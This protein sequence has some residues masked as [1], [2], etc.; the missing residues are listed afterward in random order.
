M[1]A[2]NPI[3]EKSTRRILT[4][5]LF[6]FVLDQLA[7]WFVLRSI[8]AD[9]E[10]IVIPGFFN[11]VHRDNTGAAWS[12]FTGN[13]AVL[14]LIAGVALVALFL[15]RRQFHSHTLPGQ[16]AFGLIF[17]GIIGNLTDRLLPGRHAVVDFLYFYL[18]RRGAG[19]LG[20]P[21]FNVADSAI[22]TGVTLIFLITWKNEHAPKNVTSGA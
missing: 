6:I 21:A 5:A 7:K 11:L 12:L 8:P 9:D 17:G 10:I 16:L 3:F 19:D 15:T 18:Q 2:A 20:F 14:A 1:S 22:C 4:L 13:N